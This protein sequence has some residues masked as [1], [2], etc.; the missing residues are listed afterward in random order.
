M[1]RFDHCLSRLM[2]AQGPGIIFLPLSDAR[3]GRLETF[4]TR[5]CNAIQAHPP[6]LPPPPLPPVNLHNAP[7][8]SCSSLNH[9][10]LLVH[11]LKIHLTWSVVLHVSLYVSAPSR[12]V[13]ARKEAERKPSDDSI[14]PC[15]V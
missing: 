2:P 10:C 14:C 3:S 5:R 7:G 1:S 9:S 12:W 15:N 11:R 13:S 4:Q 6:P 8:F